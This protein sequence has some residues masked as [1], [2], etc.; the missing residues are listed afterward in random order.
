MPLHAFWQ[1]IPW[2]ASIRLGDNIELQIDFMMVLS[3][4]SCEIR[5][6]WQYEYMSGRLIQLDKA[7]NQQAWKQFHERCK[8]NAASKASYR[9]YFEEERRHISSRSADQNSSLRSAI[10]S[11]HIAAIIR[12]GLLLENS[13]AAG[14]Q[15][16]IAILGKFINFQ[17][18][19]LGTPQD[20]TSTKTITELIVRIVIRERKSRA[21]I[22]TVYRD[23]TSFNFPIPEVDYE[24]DW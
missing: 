24:N 3:L 21:L 4:I 10:G 22:V 23:D 11:E 16:E 5:N 20:V 8:N 9:R 7:R 2:V 18:V 19:E 6:F 17:Y 13:C 14:S 12:Q 1:H 15:L